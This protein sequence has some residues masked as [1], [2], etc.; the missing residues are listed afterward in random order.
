M[1][2]SHSFCTETINVLCRFSTR[3]DFP[4]GVTFFLSGELS[5]GTNDMHDIKRKIIP[6]GKFNER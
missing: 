4:K 5:G 6:R 3:G 1:F 2:I